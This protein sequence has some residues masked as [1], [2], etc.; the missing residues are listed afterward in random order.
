VSINPYPGLRPFR[1]GEEHLFF[2]RER[3]IDAMI[4]VLAAQRFLA[5]VGA[6]GSGKSSLVEVGLR[7]AL[8]QGLMS[9]AGPLWR[10][11]KLSPGGSPVRSL[12]QALISDGELFPHLGGAGYS[13]EAAMEANLRLSKRGLV[14][15]LGQAH[16][17]P[18][19]NVLI[20]VDQ[21]E[22][23]FRYASAAGGTDGLTTRQEA[24]A[25]V[26]LLLE[27]PRQTDHRFYV[28]LT[29]RSDFLGDCARFD[30]L[31]EAVNKGQYLVPRMTREERRSAIVGPARVGGADVSPVLVTRLLNDVGD[32]PDQLSILQHALNR[33]WSR[34]EGK[35]PLTVKQYEDVGTMTD[36]LDQHAEEAYAAL[37]SPDLEALC[38]RVFRALTDKATDPR[39]VRRPTRFDR[40][41]EIVGA[42]P[43]EVRR[44]LHEFRTPDRPFL[45]PALP[46]KQ[47]D[48]D[49]L[50]D[51]SVVDISHESLLRVWK[52]L[53]DWADEEARSAQIF[54]DLAYDAEQKRS[55]WRDPELQMALDWREREG[56]TEAW[57][58]QYGPG[59][60]A[61]NDFL[62]ASE[63][64]RRRSRR[65]RWLL[66]GGI[67][68]VVGLAGT[69][70]YLAVVERA[71]LEE[72]RANLEERRANLQ[73][74]INRDLEERIDV[75]ASEVPFLADTVRD[76]VRTNE[77]LQFDILRRREDNQTLGTELVSLQID[78]DSL[79]AR[80]GRLERDTVDVTQRMVA[81]R[82]DRADLQTR[83]P[84]LETRRDSL[85][86]VF[87]DILVVNDSLR[88]ELLIARGGLPPVAVAD[89]VTILLPGHPP[90][91]AELPIRWVVREET[92]E[93]P[94]IE[95]RPDLLTELA[96]LLV[97]TQTLEAVVGMLSEQNLELAE[98]LAGLE[99]EHAGLLASRDS[100]AAERTAALSRVEALEE[101]LRDLRS[102][103]DR[104]A[105][106]V[107]ALARDVASTE[108]AIRVL[109]AGIA[110]LMSE[111][112]ALIEA[113]AQE[114]VGG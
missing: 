36:A 37:E 57:A 56:P 2:G 103:R 49:P 79:T 16:L 78:I 45:L 1:K 94:A 104:L 22:E 107:A 7:P 42:P 60:E 114:A 17:G 88:R 23:L 65:K 28:V 19:E 77:T 68:L 83:L 109:N 3:E 62:D 76:L 66:A 54:R 99:V 91:N 110:D 26:N 9:S 15:A 31:P 69:L 75:L 67:A 92:R 112:R 85:Q 46:E 33:T 111:Q 81:L 96:D 86:G 35:G 101:R 8:H 34:W 52:R 39:G 50:Q 27:V 74:D 25:F 80:E 51:D 44:V 59:F 72:R 100:L 53:Q 55:Y 29:M 97:Q 70:Q 38:E 24:V 82:Q 105:D 30:G 14:D 13:A 71:E 63:A 47:G 61:A 87:D 95:S 43:G 4:D 6:S 10:L 64:D 108:A 21:F 102:D 32:D 48:T 20:F 93:L 90:D 5:V 12:A 89:S 98:E 113:L 106:E 73:E 40:L 11:L 84:Q 58:E 41:C 18:R